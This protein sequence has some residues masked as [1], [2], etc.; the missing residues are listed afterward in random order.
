MAFK[1]KSIEEVRLELMRRIDLS[2]GD[3]GIGDTLIELIL[4]PIKVRLEAPI[5]YISMTIQL[6]YTECDCGA[7][8]TSNPSHHLDWC[9]LNKEN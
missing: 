9:S 5:E 7:N 8:H 2:F 4:D 1:Q 6:N 3:G